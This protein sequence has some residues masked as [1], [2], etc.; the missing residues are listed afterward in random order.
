MFTLL[1]KIFGTQQSRLI[2]K[3]KKIVK[4]I[5]AIELTYQ[6]LSEEEIVNKTSE[7]T[8][9][10]QEG[11]SLDSLLPEAFATVKNICRRLIGTDIHVSGYDQKWDMIPYDVQMIGAIAMYYGSIAEMQTGEGKT[12]T[13]SMPLY[14]NAITKKGAHLVTVN[15]YLAKRDSEWIGTIFKKLKL[16]INHLTHDVEMHQRKDVYN[17]DIVYGTASEFGFDY[18]RDNSMATS[19]EEQ[20]QRKP[21]F[22]IIDEVDSI[23]IDESRTPLIISGPSDVSFQMYDDLKYGVASVVKM[24]TE[25]C[26]KMATEARKTLDTLKTLNEEEKVSLS[27]DETILFKNTFKTLWL[28]SKGTPNNKILK[29]IKENPFLRKELDDLETYFHLDPNKK[30][31]ANMNLLIKE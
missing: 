27:K 4:E 15:D 24:Q 16:S 20:V 7:F 21:Y 1:K 30:E 2:K 5:N 14:L 31:K 10:Y 9:R 19:K 23:L 6:K 28:V 29:R 12:L 3:Y 26:N 8:Q 17:S 25:L 22:A 18:L 13:A 11:E